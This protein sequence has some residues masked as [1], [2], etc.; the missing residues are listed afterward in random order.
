MA[1]E[2]PD[3]VGSPRRR[4]ISA[5]LEDWFESDR[6]KTIGDLVNT[7]G[8]PSFAILVIVLM[9]LPTLPLP[10]GAVSHVLEVVTVV[11]ALELIIGRTG[12]WI[13]KRFRDRDFKAR[14]SPNFRDALLKRGWFAPSPGWPGCWISA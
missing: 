3:G 12:V 11:L 1:A 9:A 14:S 13:P 6:K 7:F 2:A 4:N 8:P 5:E 10:T